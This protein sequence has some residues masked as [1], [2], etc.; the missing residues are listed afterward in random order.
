MQLYPHAPEQDAAWRPRGDGHPAGGGDLGRR[1]ARSRVPGGG[2]QSAC[3][4]RCPC[5]HR[6]TPP[7]AE[8]PAPTSRAPARLRGLEDRGNPRPGANDPGAAPL[9]WE[10][11]GCA[12]A[13]AVPRWGR[14]LG[15]C[16]SWAGFQPKP[17]A[18][19]GVPR[20]GGRAAPQTRPRPRGPGCPRGGAP[21]PACPPRISRG[22]GRPWADAG[23][24]SDPGAEPPRLSWAKLPG[25]GARARP[26]LGPA[27]KA[28]WENPTHLLSSCEVIGKTAGS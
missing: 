24:A 26:G 27:K 4:P 23:L 22:R 13:G 15:H 2:P 19:G 1:L 7:G 5:G 14:G 3:R 12:G 11:R 17:G 21:R 28:G 10:G 25:G 20:P 6:A 16:P 8:P 9:T 18:G